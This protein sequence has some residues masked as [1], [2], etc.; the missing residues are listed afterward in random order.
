MH[1]SFT[2]TRLHYRLLV[3]SVHYYRATCIFSRCVFFFFFHYHSYILMYFFCLKSH[4]T[5]ILKSINIH[6]NDFPHLW[7]VVPVFPSMLWRQS[8]KIAPEPIPCRTEE[9]LRPT[10]W[11]N[12]VSKTPL[13]YRNVFDK[14][15]VIL[16]YKTWLICLIQFKI[17]GGW[18]LE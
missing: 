14:E 5:P 3:I 8:G 7:T 6:A 9:S 10:A 2:K 12:K 11:C 13:K 16:E 1:Y 18:R 15:S 4:K 17:V